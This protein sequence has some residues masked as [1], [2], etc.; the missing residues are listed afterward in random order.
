LQHVA[1]A[2]AINVQRVVDWLWEKPRSKTRPSH[3]ARLA[4][5][6]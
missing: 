5:A 1:T 4:L 3:F 6:G 2:A